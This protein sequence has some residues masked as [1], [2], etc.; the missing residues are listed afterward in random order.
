VP[1]FVGVARVFPFFFVVPSSY[2][3]MLKRPF[4]SGFAIQSGPLSNVR[5]LFLAWF[6]YLLCLNSLTRKWRNELAGG[7]IIQGAEAAAHLVV[8]QA[9]L[10]IEAIGKTL[11]RS[12]S[13]FFRVCNP[14]SKRRGCGRSCGRIARR[15]GHDVGR[16]TAFYM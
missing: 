15:A 6:T 11:R 7:Q 12:V 10:A 9:V 3:I 5:G 4:A 14:R 1:V 2:N 13:P 8:A 16:G